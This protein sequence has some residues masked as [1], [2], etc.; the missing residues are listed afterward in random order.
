MVEAICFSPNSRFL[1]SADETIHVYNVAKMRQFH[2]LRGHTDQVTC[3]T[4]DNSSK[5][6]ASGSRDKTV[7]IWEPASGRHKFTLKG[8]SNWL[9]TVEFS[10]D[11]TLLASGGMDGVVRL[12]DAR[13]GR[14]LKILKTRDKWIWSVAF[15]PDGR[16]L[17]T[18]SADGVITLYQVKTGKQLWRIKGHSKAASVAFSP[19]GGLIASGS[20]AKEVNIYDSNKG[21]K[22]KTIN[23]DPYF[24][25][26][27][28]F[29][30]DGL[31]LA[32][33]GSSI[34][35]TR[36]FETGRIIHT[37]KGP[38]GDGD[39]FAFD[40]T[41]ML[42]ATANEFPNWERVTLWN[43]MTNQIVHQFNSDPPF[44]NSVAIKVDGSLLASGGGSVVNVWNLRNGS[45]KMVI[46]HRIPEELAPSMEFQDRS[47]A[48][49]QVA[50]G[51]G[52]QPGQ[53]S[54]WPSDSLMRCPARP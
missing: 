46:D 10:P 6:L 29:S 42:V 40:P 19:S 12:W 8:H 39:Q 11:S 13:S 1:A 41:F 15:T 24:V 3:L 36:D 18:G 23:T 25:N 4:F 38:T 21:R 22:L 34:V 43:L 44:W 5:L 33:E 53:E 17:A 7:R 47:D 16:S 30:R 20:S 9:L 26:R 32:T 54:R 27:V 52:R 48:D 37:F 28:S 2:T 14:A 50:F 51:D 31:T 45:R 49:V 35:Q